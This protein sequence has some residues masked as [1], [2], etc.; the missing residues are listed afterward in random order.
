MVRRDS[1]PSTESTQ[2]IFGLMPLFLHLL[3]PLY[4]QTIFHFRLAD[5]RLNAGAEAVIKEEP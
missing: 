3:A 2:K 5:R 4:K 1:I